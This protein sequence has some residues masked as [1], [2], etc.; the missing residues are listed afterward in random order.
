MIYNLGYA[1]ATPI[2][3]VV[4][5]DAN[6]QTEPTC[7]PELPLWATLSAGL[8]GTLLIFYLALTFLILNSWQ[9][10]ADG[11]WLPVSTVH[12]ND[13]TIHKDGSHGSTDKKNHDSCIQPANGND[14]IQSSDEKE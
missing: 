1:V 14:H 11:S 6:C 9:L 8:W 4:L 7:I 13:T 3:L 2:F 10:W 5:V 12:G